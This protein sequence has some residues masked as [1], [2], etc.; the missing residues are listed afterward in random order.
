MR[1]YNLVSVELH[2]VPSVNLIDPSNVK[3]GLYSFRIFFPLM[4]NS[5]F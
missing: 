2:T 1:N 3:F 5:M 4:S